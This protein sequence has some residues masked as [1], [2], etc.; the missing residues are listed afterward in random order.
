MVRSSPAVPLPTQRETLS[1]SQREAGRDLAVTTFAVPIAMPSQLS[2]RPV[3]PER[4]SQR[5]VGLKSATSGQGA[6]LQKPRHTSPPRVFHHITQD[7]LNPP[8][9]CKFSSA[10]SPLTVHVRQLADCRQLYLTLI[11]SR[12]P[13]KQN[14]GAKQQTGNGPVVSTSARWPCI[15]VSRSMR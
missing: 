11:V 9:S 10:S 4:K 7:G 5:F 2:T 8:K 15:D 1:P 13:S 14:T 3:S 12:Q 6:P